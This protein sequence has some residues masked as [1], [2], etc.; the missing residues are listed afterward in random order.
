LF[1]DKA[2]ISFLKKVPEDVLVVFD[3]AY[4]EYV[5]DENFTSSV[6][7]VKEYD[8]LM[9]LKTFSKLYGL[10][11]LRVGYGVMNA[12]YAAL[13]ERIRKPFN[14]TAPAQAAALASLKDEAF[15]ASAKRN[16]IDTKHYCYSEFDKLGLSYVKSY[17]NFILADMQTDCMKVFDLLM[18]K[19]YI[20]R[21]VGLSTHLRITIGTKAQM[22][23]FFKALK[24]VLQ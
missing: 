21:P 10:A 22:K 13:L 12:H 9:V 14:V 11:S 8:N 20:V 24:E 23:G 5:E 17:G 4:E 15:A 6:P 18:Q 1:D 2:K 16:N 7:L 3:E 19:G